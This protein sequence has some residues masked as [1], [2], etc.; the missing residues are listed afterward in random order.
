MQKMDIGIIG[1]G[2]L[3]KML[4]E[5]GLRYNI[6][7]ATLD[8]DAQSPASGISAKHIT[9]SLQDADAL[10]KLVESAISCTYEI[11][12]INVNVLLE[13]QNAGHLFVPSPQV[14]QLIKNKGLQKQFYADNILPTSQFAVVQ[15]AAAWQN[16]IVD[17]SEY[18][19]RAFEKQRFA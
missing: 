2:Q 17:K 13:L 15:N 18:S 5:E 14:L 16:A 7:F 6:Q 3:G 12:E 10:K 19:G 8:P 11:E 4:I 1:G 9:G